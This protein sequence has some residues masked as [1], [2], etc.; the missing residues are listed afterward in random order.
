MPEIFSLTV[1]SLPNFMK[2][3]SSE[4]TIG[5]SHSEVTT[6][7]ENL[8]ITKVHTVSSDALREGEKILKS[9]E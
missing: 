8:E 2:I 1:G 3:I 6:I 4:H 5:F 7:P 9:T